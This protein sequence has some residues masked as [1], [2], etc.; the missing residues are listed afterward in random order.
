[1]EKING[2]WF[3]ADQTKEEALKQHGC[4]C[5]GCCK[6][7]MLERAL[8]PPETKPTTGKVT[9]IDHKELDI[10][11]LGH[12]HR[13]VPHLAIEFANEI[14]AKAEEA[15]QSG[16]RCRCGHLVDD[17]GWFNGDSHHDATKETGFCGCVFSQEEARASTG[18]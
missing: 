8:A 13:I 3:Y 12:H 10:E 16:L 6:A 4:T 18:P 11:F 14:L 1:M 7:I 5:D 15:R 17:H 2:Q 9:I